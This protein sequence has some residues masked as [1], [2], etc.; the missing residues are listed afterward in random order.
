MRGRHL[1]SVIA[2]VSFLLPPLAIV[3][4]GE[5]P[6][7]HTQPHSARKFHPGHYV[8]L[9]RS[10]TFQDLGEAL[11]VGITGIQIRYLWK[12]LEPEQGVYDFS[13]IHADLR[14]AEE[15]GAQ[16]V[17]MLEDKTFNG[18][19]PAPAYLRA[20]AVANRNGG[21]TI[22]RWDPVVI[23]RLHALIAA[24]G[25]EFDCHPRLEGLALQESALSLQD[26]A[27]SAN[28]YT[29]DKYAAALEQILVS[30]AASLPQSQVF[31][32]MNFLPGN[33][34][35][36]VQVAE[37]AAAAGVAMG[38]PDILPDNSALAERTYPFYA[39]FRDRMV[40][41]G[42]MQNDSYAHLR[43]DT[44]AGSKYWTLGELLDFARTE[45]HVSY[46]FWN[47]KTWP[48]PAD[49]YSWK[50]ALPVIA[51]QPLLPS[52]IPQARTDAKP[53]SGSSLPEP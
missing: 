49:S 6:D 39:Q 41:F 17:V 31:W 16:L 48:R 5:L 19:M 29:P 42:S 1:T 27:L 4:A 33:Q 9:S 24:L 47:L 8:A 22:I 28:A 36:L 53:H 7:C 10:N 50:D 14:S 13:K 43:G 51:A 34:R 46:V 30:A 12:D 38:G 37:N 23:E 11:P 15:Y 45:L 21:F 26:A 40:L 20:S 32:Y 3:E 18:D 52:A 35:L 25:R 44:A 2:M